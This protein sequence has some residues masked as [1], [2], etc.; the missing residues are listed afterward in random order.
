M[1]NAR[2]IRW[3]PAIILGATIL[4]AA[5]G[6]FGDW[7]EA[8]SA[9]PTARTNPSQTANPNSGHKPPAPDA[10]SADTAA[11]QALDAKRI[12][13]AEARFKA[14]LATKPQEPNALAGMGLVR[15]QQ[16]NFLGAVS[17]LEQAK[18]ANPSD[19]AIASALDDARFSFLT[20]EGSAALTANDL[21]TAEKRYREAL[22]LR[23][24]SV[25]ALQGLSGTLLGEKR[26]DEAQDLLEKSLTRQ[27]AAGAGPAAGIE[28]LLADL[29]LER[30]QPQLAYP[31][32]RQVLREDAQNADAWAGLLTALHLTGHDAEAT[33]E[34]MRI[35]AAIRAQLQANPS[36]AQMMIGAQMIGQPP[37]ADAPSLPPA[38]P[39]AADVAI[40][41]A[42]QL[43]NSADDAGLYRELMQLGA[44][45]DLS[46]GQRRAV[47]VIWV[48][49]AVRRARQA[50]AVGET[51][52]ATDLLDA[53]A[54]SSPDDA[55]A[56]VSAALPSAD[57]PQQL[58]VLLNPA[59][60]N[61]GSVASSSIAPSAGQIAPSPVASSAGQNAASPV[62]QTDAQSGEV[63]QPYVTYIASPPAPMRAPIARP[64]NSVA[65]QPQP[66]AGLPA[67]NAGQYTKAASVHAAQREQAATPAHSAKAETTPHLTPAP[68]V[69][70]P[71]AQP[72]SHGSDVPDTGDQQYPQPPKPPKP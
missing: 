18:Q 50:L 17:F 6:I 24:G 4:G 60:L 3:A 7:L 70:Q 52:R 51:Q 30:G 19:K 44:R 43:L 11:Y 9:P 28:L 38:Q 65:A 66:V 35:P 56:A 34:T 54:R 22:E 40:Q 31:V 46:D 23:P 68:Q 16:G 32:Y 67:G 47:Q 49:W 36:Y 71:A 25:D 53:A 37:P 26:L 33:A 8:Q 2:G 61:P 5:L 69:T 62:P 45:A 39:V 29:Y 72:A 21:G 14:V 41:N 27:A 57:R 13:D 15:M 58:S 64:G 12:D 20:G 59:P 63:Y 55:A 1:M 48:E 42:R 10:A